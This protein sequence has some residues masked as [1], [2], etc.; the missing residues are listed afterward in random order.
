MSTCVRYWEGLSAHEDYEMA[1]PDQAHCRR[2]IRRA[3]P[4]PLLTQSRGRSVAGSSACRWTSIFL[5]HSA[6]QHIPTPRKYVRKIFTSNALA[7]SFFG[8]MNVFAFHRDRTFYPRQFST[9]P[10][11]VA[12]YI[13]MI[14]VCETGKN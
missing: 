9:E 2:L 5:E 8:H 1:I 13:K 11:P 6:S 4:T 10:L 3:V 14:E 12:A 7:Y